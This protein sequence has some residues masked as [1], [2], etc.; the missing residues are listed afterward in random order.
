[1]NHASEQYA[2]SIILQN[3]TQLQ[4]CDT[5]IYHY[6]Y[7]VKKQIMDQFLAKNINEKWARKSLN[8]KLNDVKDW[9]KTL[10]YYFEKHELLLKDNAV[11]AFNENKFRNGYYWTMK[12]FFKNPIIGKKFLNDVL[13]HTKRKITGK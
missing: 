3:N 2:F 8:E 9:T 12:A 6:W 13:Y 10:P 7:R 1:M 5:V 4:A 11:Q